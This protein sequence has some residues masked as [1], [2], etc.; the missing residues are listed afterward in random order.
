LPTPGTR[1][2]AATIAREGRKVGVALLAASQVNDLGAF[3]TGPEGE[4]LRSSLLMG[5]G[6][7]MR[8]KANSAKGIFNVAIDPRS[9]P[10]IP[11]YGFLVD[12]EDRSAP[13][14]GWF[15]DDETAAKWADHIRWSTLDQVAAGAAG[16]DYLERHLL[17]EAARA[18]RRARVQA[19]R[20]GRLHTTITRT[21][22][23]M[24]KT[25]ASGY[26]V[27]QFPTWDPSLFTKASAPALSPGHRAV[28]QALTEG[29][30]L[31][32]GQRYCKPSTMAAEVGLTERWVHTILKDLVAHEAVR[33][34][35]TQG[36]YY[37]TGKQLADVAA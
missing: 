8:T 28:V 19:A 18:E 26:A 20:E 36:H 16:P 4:A 23:A 35:E 12:P 25:S 22:P 37:P 15:V 11:G 31:V 5:N 21:V 10:K 9:F 29:R 13:Y 1:R 34:G 2:K 3:G 24:P 14:R 32:A 6:I 17:R 30:G 27:L 7:I 33:K